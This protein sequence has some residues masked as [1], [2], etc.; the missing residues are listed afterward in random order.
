M[1]RVARIFE[2][3]EALLE[4]RESQ[5]AVEA[6]LVQRA[7]LIQIIRRSLTELHD[8]RRLVAGTPAEAEDLDRIN[9]C[10]QVLG[11]AKDQRGPDLILQSRR[12]I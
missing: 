6:L 7:W 3:V 2:N 4:G 11:W 9:Y 10:E 12:M 1:N 8:H 5:R